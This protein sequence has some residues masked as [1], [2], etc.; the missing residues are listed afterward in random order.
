VKKR[1][2]LTT[3]VTLTAICAPATQAIGVPA[4]SPGGAVGQVQSEQ[5]VPVAPPGGY[6][7]WS[8]PAPRAVAASTT[9]GSSRADG[10][11]FADAAVGLGVGLGVAFLA[12]GRARGRRSVPADA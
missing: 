11:D 10:F 12:L 8:R 9:D 5:A 4:H 3:A 1:L 2:A 7:A 6:A